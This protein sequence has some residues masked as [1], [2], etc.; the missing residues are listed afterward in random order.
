MGSVT[1]QIKN[2]QRKSEQGNVLFLILI[3]VALFAALSYAVTQSTRSG[4]GSADRETSILNSAAMT[5]YPAAMRTSLVR[6]V[7]AGTSVD[8]LKFNP[9]SNNF[10]GVTDTDELVFHPLGGGA[11]YQTAPSE[12]ISGGT[13]EWTFNANFN[14]PQIGLDPGSPGIGGDGN[15]IIAFLP[16]VSTGICERTNA[17][18]GINTTDCALNGNIPTLLTGSDATEIDIL[19]DDAYNFATE[20]S[21]TEIIQGNNSG[22]TC[23]AFTAQPSGCFYDGTRNV[24]YSVLL[25]R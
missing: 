10:G 20:T 18:F 6:M 25:E 16:N 12:L 4:G 8:A 13:G 17:Q 22:G 24:F 3:A 15:D 5:Q 14:V 7:L 21:D 2:T 9:P 19:M 23:S 1:M 11:L